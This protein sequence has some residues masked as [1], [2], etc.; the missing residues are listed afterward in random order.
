M[1]SELPSGAVGDEAD[2]VSNLHRGRRAPF[3]QLPDA[4]MDDTKISPMAKV[5]YWYLLR[6]ADYGNH[7]ARVS[8]GTIAQRVGLSASSKRTVRGWLSELTE[9]GWVEVVRRRSDD[10]KADL[11]SDYVVHTAPPGREAVPPPDAAPGGTPAPGGSAAPGGRGS[12]APGVGAA[13]PHSP[14]RCSPTS[15]STSGRNSAPSP[16][17]GLFEPPPKTK[18]RGSRLPAGF[19]VNPEMIA[20]KRENAPH[21]H[22]R[23]ELAQFKDHWAAAAGASAVKLDWVAA[24]RTWMRRAEADWLRREQQQQRPRPTGTRTRTDPTT[25]H[26]REEY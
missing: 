25:G 1:S 13:E 23:N 9:A 26:M 17:D 18:K 15:K 10:G 6:I 2:P 21:V 8:V 7:Q 5:V 14:R 12:A 3:K 4:V 19:D 16:T 24:W 11:A 22:L 20:W